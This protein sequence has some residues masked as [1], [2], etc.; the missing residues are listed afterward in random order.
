MVLQGVLAR[1]R[2]GGRLAILTTCMGVFLAGV[3]GIGIQGM[4][5]ILADL[6]TVYEDR[7]VCLVQ[8][9]TIQRDV[10]RIRV[11]VRAMADSDPAKHAEPAAAIEAAEKEIAAQ[12]RDYLATYLPPEEKA[13]A[14]RITAALPPF[15]EARKAATAAITA[16]TADK[17]LIDAVTVTGRAVLKGLEED[18]ALQ[19]R[20][21]K[22]EFDKGSATATI[23]IEAGLAAAAAALILGGLLAL[24]IT[25]AI[26]IPLNGILAVMGRLAHGDLSVSVPGGER[27]DEVGD[28]AKAVAVFH[29]N[30]E[31]N[32]R[33][34]AE[35]KAAQERRE[36]R[37]RRIE[38]LTRSFDGAV[39][40]VLSSVSGAADQMQSTAQAMSA[41][42]EQTSLQAGTVA[43]ATD[44]ATAN[45]QTV[46]SAAEQLSSSVREIG[47]QVEESNRISRAA[48]EE[49]ERTDGTMKGLAEKSARIGE[50]VN[51]INDIASQTNLLALNATIEAARA[52]DAGKGFAVVA[53]EVKNLANQTGRATEEISAQVAEV[54]AATKD[55]VGAISGIVARIGEIGEIAAAIAA[56]V[57]QQ[58]AATV[59]IARNV[60]QAAAGSQEVA[61]T[62][63]GVT[64][65]A[66]ETGTAATQ[67]LS[68]AR[69]LAEQAGSLRHEVTSFL[70]GVK[71]A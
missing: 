43:A 47:R 57:E 58:S 29:S 14:D 19:D 8:L 28:I 17:A 49:A 26:T 59:E 15:L 66:G 45:I 3:A 32:Q 21:A 54:Q 42:A 30:M 24:L 46:A 25:R 36:G 55:A 37:T 53:N 18:I 38:E 1:T 40:V 70:Q 52:G 31:A 33:M 65:A 60:A 61:S 27:V 68:S 4:T 6:K 51:L 13:I 22:Q 64:Q 11:A 7:T 23:M 62:I 69:Q 67:V 48:S 44:Q 35:Q 39:S 2:I 20:I 41:N 16:G 71:A 63:V 12:W 9:A 10:Y 5:A 34:A 50:V 56:A